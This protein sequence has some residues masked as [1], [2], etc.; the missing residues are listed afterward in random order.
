LKHCV[1]GCDWEL[2]VSEIITIEISKI[3]DP[4][5]KQKIQLL[6]KSAVEKVKYNAVIKSR[7]AEFRKQHV[8][9]FDSLHLAA[10]EY[11]NANIFLTTDVQLLKTAARTNLKIRI[12]NPLNYYM[13]VM[14]DGQFGN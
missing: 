12:A 10:A 8:K 1:S 6:Y 2:I 4:V 3:Q 5:K 11:A 13:E 7:A 9:L 14:N